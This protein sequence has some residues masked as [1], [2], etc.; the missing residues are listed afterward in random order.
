MKDWFWYVLGASLV[1]SIIYSANGVDTTDYFYNG[2]DFGKLPV[3][4]IIALMLDMAFTLF[5]QGLYSAKTAKAFGKGTGFAVALF[6]F[7]NICWLILGF[8]SA[9]YNKK[10]ALGTSSKE[11]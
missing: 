1:F 9:K 6:F 8:G 10:V 3:I 7:P 11:K 4:V 2:V 5:V